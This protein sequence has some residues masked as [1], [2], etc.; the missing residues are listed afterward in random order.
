M[1]LFP[2]SGIRLF[3]LLSGCLLQGL[4][5]AQGIGGV[6]RRFP[7][8][9]ARI[10]IFADQLPA[11]MTDAQ[12]RFAATHYV[13]CQK[14]MRSW[15]RR[16]RQLN[17]GFLVLHYQLAVGTGPAAFVHGDEWT[18][19][20]A[21]V[22]RHEDWFL[23]DTQGRRLLQPDWNW[24]VMDIRFADNRPATGF[25]DYWLATALQRMR[26]NEDDGCFADSY[27]QDILINQLKPP[28]VWFT[29]PE[30]N[31]RF[32]L[33]NLNRYG[34]FCA[35]GFHRQP[36]RFYYLP[37]LGGMV[38]TWDTVTNLA[39]GD[40]GMNE[41][42]CA[43]GPGH[44]YSEDDWRLQMSRVLALA[45]RNKILLCQTGT[46]PANA[47]HRWFIVGSY[48]LTKG[49]RS[50]L[51]MFQKSTLEWYPE[52]TLDLGPYLQEPQPDVAAYWKPEW[53]VYRR[54]YAKGMVLVNPTSEPVTIPDL[55]GTYR[56]VA[57]QGG[58]IV[59]ADG[60]APGTLTTQSVRSVTI[61]AHSAR[62]LLNR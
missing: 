19:D 62:V 7:D 29:D 22:T 9:R 40:G 17:P 21:Q 52:Y 25:P 10:L 26:D 23:H 34:A 53:K 57:A 12:W 5:A 27:T 36:E 31:K 32:W 30:A 38:T 48:L 8:T 1:G 55:G 50:Y 42:F 13:G 54:D 51:N 20:F 2:Q 39:V 35:Q 14:E 41:G 11:Q 33:P 45:S 44:Y 24:Y 49:H 46:D 60:Q 47:D 61:P 37:N 59:S 28:F 15:T 43:S 4:C 58:G 6:A 16:M 3:L 18:N 56:L